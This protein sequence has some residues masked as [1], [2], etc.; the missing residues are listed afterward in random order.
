M[1]CSEERSSEPEAQQAWVVRLRAPVSLTT[2]RGLSGQHLLG[3]WSASASDEDCTM[4]V[5][6]RARVQETGSGSISQETRMPI[7]TNAPRRNRFRFVT[8]HA[9]CLDE[10]QKSIV[11]AQSRPWPGRR[12][13]GIPQTHG[14]RSSRRAAGSPRRMT[15]WPMSSVQTNPTRSGAVSSPN[16]FS[17]P[18]SSSGTF[19]S[20]QRVFV[21]GRRAVEPCFDPAPVAGRRYAQADGLSRWDHR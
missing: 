16:G 7:A 17:F 1:Q 12:A 5:A 19:Q 8:Q 14:K 11:V 10:Q 2:G 18:C 6:E 4:S 20:R 9:E 3:R 15:I 13:P 21:G